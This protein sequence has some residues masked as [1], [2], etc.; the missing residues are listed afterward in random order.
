MK[1]KVKTIIFVAATL[2]IILL[3]ASLFI[4]LKNNPPLQHSMTVVSDNLQS[5]VIDLPNGGVGKI[6]ITGV[7]VNNNQ[8]PEKVK[9]QY[10][11]S[12]EGVKL[13]DNSNEINKANFY[14]LKEKSI[15]PDTDIYQAKYGLNVVS[16]K[17]IETITVK[18]KYF[19]M[20][21]KKKVS[22]GMK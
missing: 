15:P 7:K 13:L 2:I 11:L 4:Y 1:K 14:S 3:I 10:L 21:Y 17:R 12:E 19:G 9:I 18:Y 5:V 20:N 6:E 8:S 22:K 16:D